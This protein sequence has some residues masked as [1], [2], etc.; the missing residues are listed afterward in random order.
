MQRQA[1][2]VDPVRGERKLTSR[3][4]PGDAGQL[5]LPGEFVAQVEAPEVEGQLEPQ[6]AEEAPDVV[7]RLRDRVRDQVDPSSPDILQRPE[8]VLVA[9][10]IVKL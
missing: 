5:P 9:G 7:S 10:G 3:Q 2:V 6:H 8:A 1:D 4:R